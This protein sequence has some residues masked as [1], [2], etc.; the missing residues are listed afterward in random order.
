G[1]VVPTRV[2]RSKGRARRAG[3]LVYLRDRAGDEDNPALFA[4]IARR[5][6]VVAVADVRGFGETMS[7]RHAAD[8]KLDYFDP[9]NGRDSEFAYTSL[10]IGRTLL[11]MRVWDALNVVQ[12]VHSRGDMGGVRVSI[13]GRGEAGVV[14]LFAAAVGA[15]VSGVAVE[16]ILSS[17]AD[18]ARNE[19]QK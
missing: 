15:N 1:I 16:G 12:Y 10:S 2:I 11:G 5:V 13:L 8:G 4:E 14:A 19:F 3:A 9:F 18:I 7:K 6:G 17:Y